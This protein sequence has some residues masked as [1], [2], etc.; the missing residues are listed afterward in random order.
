MQGTIRGPYSP[1]TRSLRH[2]RKARS[3][4][5]WSSLHSPRHVQLLLQVRISTKKFIYP[6]FNCFDRHI[7]ERALDI[8]EAEKRQIAEEQNC[9]GTQGQLIIYYVERLILFLPLCSFF[10]RREFKTLNR[11]TGKHAHCVSACCFARLMLSP[12][13]YCYNSSFFQFYFRTKY[14]SG[15]KLRLNLRRAEKHSHLNGLSRVLLVCFHM[16]PSSYTL[17]P[18]YFYI[19]MRRFRSPSE[20][21]TLP[22]THP[23]GQFAGSAI[24]LRLFIG[25]K[26][27]FLQ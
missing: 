27:I 20:I 6:L 17:N 9:S 5:P 13:W 12:T 19:A 21:V 14:S 10:R 8:A 24:S 3:L 25:N 7:R 22:L 23:Q 18:F 11:Q 15:L 16:L 1:R 26:V 2:Q 4:S